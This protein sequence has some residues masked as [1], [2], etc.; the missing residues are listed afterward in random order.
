MGNLQD[1]VK[2]AADY[3]TLSNEEEERA[4]LPKSG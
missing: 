1:V 4:V 3:V 2:Q